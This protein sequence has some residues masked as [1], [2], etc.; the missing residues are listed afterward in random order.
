[1]PFG[2]NMGYAGDI[3]TRGRITVQDKKRLMRDAGMLVVD[4][5]SQIHLALQELEL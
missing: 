2:H 4:R 5:I 1:M 3:L